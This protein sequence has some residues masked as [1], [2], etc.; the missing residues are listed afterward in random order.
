LFGGGQ[1]SPSKEWVIGLTPHVRYDFATGTRLVPFFDGGAGVT[2]TG[3]GPPDMS[4]TFEFNL[5]VTTG[6]YWFL[7]DDLAMTGEVSY[8]HMSCA[9]IHH[10]NLGA[11]NVI[12][13]I[14]LTWFF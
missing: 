11:N 7:R 8:M 10:P 4:G 5:Q 3:I 9:G 1:Y 2:A 13:M 12:F 14:G 6:A